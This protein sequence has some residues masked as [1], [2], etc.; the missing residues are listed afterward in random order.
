I[1]LHRRHRCALKDAL[2]KRFSIFPIKGLTISYHFVKHGAQTEEVR[3]RIDGLATNLLGRH[4]VQD[5]RDAG[6]LSSKLAYAGDTVS[7]NSDGAVPAAH[8]FG[9]LQTI[10][11]Y[12]VGVSVI[13]T[14]AHLPADI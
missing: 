8:D 10:V 13:E 12:V 11:K 4:V 2:T 6:H 3:P 7:Q 14:A 1:Y 9:G 5:R